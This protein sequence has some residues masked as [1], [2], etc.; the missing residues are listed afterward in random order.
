MRHRGMSVKFT[1]VKSCSFPIEIYTV[2]FYLQ[3]MEGGNFATYFQQCG[4]LFSPQVS[5]SLLFQPRNYLF[6]SHFNFPGIKTEVYTPTDNRIEFIT[7]D[8]IDILA[9]KFVFDIDDYPP[10]RSSQSRRSL[11]PSLTCA[12]EKSA[13]KLTS[14]FNSELSSKIGL[15]QRLH[16]HS[17]ESS[18]VQYLFSF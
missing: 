9:L 5:E 2:E 16:L 8:T 11:S 7:Q 12:P 10:F 15:I 13:Q 18:C 14:T 6:R 1:I 17:N 3:Y 4:S